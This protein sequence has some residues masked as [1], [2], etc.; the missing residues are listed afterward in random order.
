MRLSKNIAISLL[1]EQ[2]NLITDESEEQVKQYAFF[3]DSM[4]REAADLYPFHTPYKNLVL[5]ALRLAS[6]FHTV[7]SEREEEISHQK[8]I[9]SFIDK[10][11]SL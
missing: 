6:N 8:K 9:L 7:N 11:L 3:L 1:N 5:V 2:H 4:L 10:E